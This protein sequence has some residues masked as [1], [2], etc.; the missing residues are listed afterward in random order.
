M[1][2]LSD[3]V[4]TSITILND[5]DE[6]IGGFLSPEYA[7]VVFPNG[8]Y[9]GVAIRTDG[10]YNVALKDYNTYMDF[11]RLVPFG[12]DNGTVD[13][14]S[15]EEVCEVLDIIKRLNHSGS[16]DNNVCRSCRGT[17][18]FGELEGSL[19]ICPDCHGTGKYRDLTTQ[20]SGG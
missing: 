16:Y 4:S 3:Y 11:S 10:T 5:M 20:N 15:E 2:K 12:K 14:K 7:R 13:C 17:G 9:G 19:L 1:G 18:D 6:V 8:W